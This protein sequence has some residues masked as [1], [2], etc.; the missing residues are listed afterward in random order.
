MLAERRNW[1][2]ADFSTPKPPRG[3]GAGATGC[4]KGFAALMLVL[5]IVRVTDI[6]GYFAG[7]GIG[8]PKLWPRVSPKKTWPARIGG[9][10]AACR[11]RELWPRLIW[12]R[13]GRVAA[14]RPVGRLQLGDLFEAAVKRRFGVKDIH[15]IIPGH[16]GLWTATDVC[17]QAVLVAAISG[18]CE[19][20]RME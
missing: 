13:P 19:S 17:R 12:A 1:V 18:S 3:V 15:H 11:R 2:A 5:L 9:F 8:G 16:D 7:R 6:G 10:G 14:G 4:G 20:A